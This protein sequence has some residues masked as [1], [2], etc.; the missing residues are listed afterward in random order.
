[1]LIP[2]ISVGAVRKTS[3]IRNQRSPVRAGA[4]ASP[5][6]EGAALAAGRRVCGGGGI[7]SRVRYVRATRRRRPGSV[8]P[9]TP[10][11]ANPAAVHRGTS[12]R[13]SHWRTAT[14][15]MTPAQPLN[16]L[17]LRREIE[18]A[19]RKPIGCAAALSAR[20]RSRPTWRSADL[21][22][23]S[24]QS[25]RCRRAGEGSGN[26][27]GIEPGRKRNEER[28]RRRDQIVLDDAVRR[29]LLAMT[30][31]FREVWDRQSTPN[32]ER[33]RLLAYIVEDVTLIED[34]GGAEYENPR[35]LQRR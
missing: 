10:L 22:Y 14:G 3:G 25:P 18:L 35:P 12:H 11:V 7:T 1:M 15:G 16:C 26:G 17:E 20:S 6:R 29:Q 23:R 34:S 9:G 30:T 28:A 33:K 21:C 19:T 5:P 27:S 2:A 4:R 32:R 31:D 13:Q 24:G 8:R